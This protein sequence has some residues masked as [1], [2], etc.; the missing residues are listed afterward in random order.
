MHYH[1]IG[2]LYH[3]T[4]GSID[5]FLT[6]RLCL[7]AADARGR[8]YRGDIDHAPWP[9]QRADAQIET[10][11]MTDALGLRLPAGPSLLHF[12]RRLDVMAWNLVRLER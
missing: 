12:A 11:T 7:Y 6:N 1:P 2:N 4:P 10:N 5:D 8:L 3:S 9:L